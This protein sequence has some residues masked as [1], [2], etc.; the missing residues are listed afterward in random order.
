MICDHDLVENLKGEK[1]KDAFDS[2]DKTGAVE[3]QYDNGFVGDEFALPLST[4][5]DK[6]NKIDES[7]IVEFYVI[8][9]DFSWCYIVTHERDA[10]GP[11]FIKNNSFYN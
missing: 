7:G 1:A 11:F 6:A 8:G 2:A 9:K 3:F 10:C 4:E 5:H